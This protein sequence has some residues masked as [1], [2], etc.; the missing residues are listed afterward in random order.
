MIPKK[1]DGLVGIENAEDRHEHILGKLMVAV[2]KI[3]KQ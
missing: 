2:A 1:R 3:A